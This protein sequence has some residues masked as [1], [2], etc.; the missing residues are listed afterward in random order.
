MDII[1][2]K[3]N[4][5]LSTN[6]KNDLNIRE[7]NYFMQSQVCV[8]ARTSNKIQVECRLCT[9]QDSIYSIEV[10]KFVA[11]FRNIYRANIN[12]PIYST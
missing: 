5:N 3:F 2:L 1:N 11:F 9:K 6:L 8:T 12:V 7:P 10:T 4:Q